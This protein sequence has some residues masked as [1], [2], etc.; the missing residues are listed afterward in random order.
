MDR[1]RIPGVCSHVMIDHVSLRCRDIAASKRFYQAALAPLG[2]AVVM[3]FP[4]AV[5]LG[6]DG[7]PDFWLSRGEPGTTSHIAFQCRDREPV[8]KFHAAA[9]AAGA[10]DNGAPGVRSHYHA[11]YYGAYVLD[12]D[13]NNVEVVCHRSMSAAPPNAAK[14]SKPRGPARKKAKPAGGTIKKKA[15][16][17]R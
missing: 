10:R 13:G 12:L 2:Y 6:A 1:G 14:R 9:L 7:K 16:R 17:R 3:E 5:G 11:N 8:A 15:R 4:D